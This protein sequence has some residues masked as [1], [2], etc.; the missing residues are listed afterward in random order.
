MIT[1][2]QFE[3]AQ[4]R[5]VEMI[6]QAHIL[7]NEEEQQ[8]IE[9]AD[10]SLNN[11][12]KEGAQILT[13]VETERVGI[14]L[15]VLFPHQTLPEHWHPPVGDDPGKEETFRL[16]SGTLY[17]YVPGPDNLKEGFVPEGKE[18]YYTVRHEI[19][20]KPTDQFTVKPGDKHWF[21]A[22]SEGAVMYTYATCTRDGLDGFS[23][24]NGQRV[25]TFADE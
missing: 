19:V 1:R 2:K 22:G 18:D 16:V 4:K 10:Y 21:Q 14:R 7:I 24:P 12:E 25:T 5:A 6:Q 11:L 17:L 9:I 23:D 8:R 15:I 3:S 13:L 20:M